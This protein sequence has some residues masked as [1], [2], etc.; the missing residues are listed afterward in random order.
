M[1][2]FKTVCV[3]VVYY[4]FP[5]EKYLQGPYRHVSPDGV[6]LKVIDEFTE[7]STLIGL[8]CMGWK[9]E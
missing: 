3:D 8:A 6:R 1:E 4:T 9:A 2:V 7:I 5:S